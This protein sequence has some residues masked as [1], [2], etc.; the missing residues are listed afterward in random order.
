M[1]ITLG[2]ENSEQAV[3]NI[4]D[5]AG[6]IPEE[7][8]GKIWVYFHYL[9]AADRNRGGSVY[10]SETIIVEEHGWEPCSMEHCR[11]GGIQDWV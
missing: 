2:S 1:T 7:T 8:M 5:N 9:R 4:A 6:G 10:M 11:R 3:V